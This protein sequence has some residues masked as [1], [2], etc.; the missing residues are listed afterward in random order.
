MLAA[1]QH[2][3]YDRT[4]LSKAMKLNAK[5]I[6]LRPQEFW[7]EWNVEVSLNSEVTE[8]DAEAKKV[9][10]KVGSEIKFVQ[11]EAALVATGATPNR[12]AFIPGI[13]QLYTE[14]LLSQA[15]TLRALWYSEI[16][17]RHTLSTRR[18]KERT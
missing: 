18:P 6:Q 1:E 9:T 16:L 7:D 2:L 11:Y 12:L 3:P 10:Y 15:M 8:L 13:V 17:K 14:I 4:K 5:Q